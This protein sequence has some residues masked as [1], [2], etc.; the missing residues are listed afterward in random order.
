M[1]NPKLKE[2]WEGYW[3]KGFELDFGV[4][5]WTDGRKYEGYWKEDKQ[6]GESKLLHY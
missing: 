3:D 1:K 2:I 5:I 4:F 6:H